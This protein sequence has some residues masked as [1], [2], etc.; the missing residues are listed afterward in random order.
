MVHM[1]ICRICLIMFS[2]PLPDALSEANVSLYYDKWMTE[3][4]RVL[5]LSY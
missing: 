2:I 4:Y 5:L 1:Y 3:H